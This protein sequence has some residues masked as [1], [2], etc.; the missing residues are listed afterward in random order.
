MPTAQ[1]RLWAYSQWGVITMKLF[2][3]IL[4]YV[5]TALAA[6]A[7]TLFFCANTL[8]GSVKLSQVEYLIESC[9]IGEADMAKVEDAAAE[10]MIAS[11]G[12]R[13]SYYLNAQD[14]ADHKEQTENAYVGIGITIS[15]DEEGRGFLILEVQ[16][17][18]GAQEVG[19]LPGD[20][21]I[22]AQGESTQGIS[23]SQLRNLIRGPEGTMAE[24]EILR[25]G[26]TLSF[27]VERRQI[28]TQVVV[29]QL[30]E[31]N[32]GLIAIRNFDSRC[33]KE[34][35][36]AIEALRQQ[37][38][39]ALIFDVRNNPGGYAT[40][41]VEL[42]DYL[43]PEGELFR[44]VD[45]TGK[46]KV[47]YSD[48][49]F[50]DMPIA[51]LCNE[52]SYSAAEFFPA[53][54]QEYDAGTVVGTHTCGKGYFQYTYELS[55]G[56]GVGLSVGKYYTPSGKSLADTGIQ[57]DI[58]VEVDDE[59]RAAIYYGTLKPEEDP[60]IQAAIQALNAEN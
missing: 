60:Q 57:P 42:L 53:A 17:G 38:A 33:A 32:I 58:L 19:L 28:L 40:E 44:T 27:Q 59:T 39:Q 11:L 41:L 54:I 6:C 10:A 50:L 43:L 21:I 47:D 37:G 16:P 12:D 46:E 22:S 29:Y 51:V 48:A 18:S 14:F 3:R 25:D 34:S 7:V 56:S 52:D 15:E 20:I 24:L 5:A 31:D 45:Y 30:L 4:S 13:W 49:A 26:R 36:A 1:N 8:S 35:I 2:F 9:F 55:D 23:T